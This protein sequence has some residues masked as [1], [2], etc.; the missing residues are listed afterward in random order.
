MNNTI[1]YI[2]LII[3]PAFLFSQNLTDERAKQFIE[4]LISNSQ[5]LENFVDSTEMSLS[6]RL[7]IS[8]LNSKNKFLISND[9]ES[10]VKENILN[11]K[12]RYNYNLKN[13]EPNYTQLLLEVPKERIKLEYFFY[14]S[15]LISKPYYYSKK[16]EIVT[17]KYF[18][19]HIS[20]SSLINNYSISSLDS[21]VDSMLSDL[22]CTNS[23]IQQLEKEKIHY[24]L[25]KDQ[26]EIKQLTNY[27]ARGLYFIAFDYIIS[28]FN[29]HYHEIAHLLIN[30]NLKSNELYTLPLL[31]E[32]FAVAYG[33]RGGKEPNV[34]L[35]VGKF[36]IK[37]DFLNYDMLLSKKD[38]YQFDASMSYPVAG[39]YTKFLIETLGISKFLDLYKF[40]STDLDS[41]NTISIGSNNLPSKSEWIEF[42]NQQTKINPIQVSNIDESN[43]IIPVFGNKDYSICES[44]NKYIFRIKNSICIQVDEN[45]DNYKSKSFDEIFPER[46]YHNEKYIIIANSNEVSVYNLYTN[47]LMGKYIKGF[48][49]SNKDVLQKNGL[50]LFSIRKDLFDEPLNEWNIVKKE[51]K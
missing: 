13:L 28:T 36:L 11:G 23:A 7:G 14:N 47:S 37:S 33:G 5:N 22:D 48:S 44:N 40:Y 21:F 39:L 2:L 10:S 4:S 18:T 31:Q 32:G 45:V 51:F 27:S 3:F 15:K 46:K 34:I 49:T 41:I 38:F 17:S 30:Y 29:S 20:D 16:W 42:V 26:A 9:L 8:Y 50:S 24:F 6:K 12:V 25:C 1:F 43:C 35:E 19:F